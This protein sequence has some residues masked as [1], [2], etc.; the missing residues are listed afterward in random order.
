MEALL[1]ALIYM[2][3]ASWQLSAILAGVA[4]VLLQRHRRAGIK[5]ATRGLQVLAAASLVAICLYHFAAISM[6]YF[7]CRGVY[8]IF[9]S[10]SPLLS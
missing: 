8:Y 10:L 9:T 3:I 2:A 6:A 7:V 1:R 5:I 4:Q